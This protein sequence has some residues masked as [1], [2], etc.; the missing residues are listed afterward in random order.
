MLRIGVIGTGSIAPAHIS[1]Y[2]AFPEDCVIVGVAG[3]RPH[4]AAAIANRFQL[5]DAVTYDD[6]FELIAAGGVDLVSIATPPRSHAAL[7]IAALEAGSNVLVE[8]PMAPSLDECDAMLTAQR[9][10]GKLLSVVAQNRFR[11]DMGTLKAVI[12]SGLIGDV[13]HIRV[14]SAWWRGPSYYDKSWRGTWESEGGGCTMNHAIHHIDLVLW[15][16][17]RPS[18]V[19]AML[20]NAQHD[21]AQVEDLSVAILRYGMALAQLTSSVVHHGEEQEIV[22]H[23]RYARV[24]QPWRVVAEVARP[25]GLPTP[26]GDRDLVENLNAL[27]ATSP[28]LEHEGHAGQVNDVIAAIRDHRHPLVDGED[29]RNAV[30]VATAIYKASLERRAVTL[31]LQ[32]ED[33]YY[34]SGHL[35]SESPQLR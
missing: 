10:S 26:G 16:M 17:G 4:T 13:S 14:E 18:E 19:V 30:E 5:T 31:P 12:D 23:G 33:P 29:G 34:C 20:T 22:V 32:P 28:G 15:L 27:A 3:N 21:N 11:A 7:S 35:A 9:T 1:G 24:S 25:D 6:P 8:K 2:L